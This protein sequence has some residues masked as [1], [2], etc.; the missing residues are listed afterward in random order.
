MISFLDTTTKRGPDPATLLCG[1]AVQPIVTN[2]IGVLGSGCPD[3]MMDGVACCLTKA[4]T[5][6]KDMSGVPV[7]GLLQ[8]RG[9]MPPAPSPCIPMGANVVPRLV[10]IGATAR[11]HMDRLILGNT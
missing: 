8:N 5:A 11:R 6:W 10:V 1:T 4:D 2:T 7:T 3:R 9:S